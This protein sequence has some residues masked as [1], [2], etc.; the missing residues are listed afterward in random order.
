MTATVLDSLAEH[1]ALEYLLYFVYPAG[2]DTNEL[3][4]RLINHFGDF[5]KVDGGRT[6]TN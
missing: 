5:C 2:M 4:H 3:A 6:R 1:E